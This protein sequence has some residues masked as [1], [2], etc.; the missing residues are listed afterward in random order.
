MA[1]HCRGLGSSCQAAVRVVVE[2]RE[3]P[4]LR[5]IAKESKFNGRP[6]IKDDE[7]DS[8]RQ[9]TSHSDLLFYASDGWSSAVS[10]CFQFGFFGNSGISGNLL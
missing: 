6:L 9:K 5:N 8:P 1:E 4:E 2:C 3:S 10:L 7:T